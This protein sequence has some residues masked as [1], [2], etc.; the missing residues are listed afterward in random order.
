M[1]AFSADGK[2]V[3]VGR[4]QGGDVQ[5]GDVVAIL[6]G[7]A[8]GT[9]AARRRM[10]WT[11]R[12]TCSTSRCRRSPTPSPICQGFVSEV[13]EGN[14][15]DIRG[16]RRSDGFV[17]AGNHFG[18]R[19]VGNHLLGGGLAWRMMAC[20]TE[21]PVIW[22]WSHVPFLGGVVEGNMLED[23]EQGG[24]V[25]VEHSI[26]I[27]TNKGRTYMSMQ[28]RD[29]VVRWSEP[30]LARRRP[31]RGAEGAAGGPDGGLPAV[32][33]PVRV[34]GLGVGNTPGCPAGLSRCAGAGRPRGPVQRARRS[35]IASTSSRPPRAPSTAVGARPVAAARGRSDERAEAACPDA[36]C[37]LRLDRP[38]RADEAAFP[39]TTKTGEACSSSID[40]DDP[41]RAGLSLGRGRACSGSAGSSTMP[42]GRPSS[43]VFPL[44]KGEFGIGDPQLGTLSSAFMLLYA[45]T[46]PFTGYTVDR[47]SRRFLIAAGLAF[48]S[49]ICAATGLARSFVQL[50]LFRAAEGLGESFYFPASM[51]VL[52]DYHGPRT[53]S[54]AMSLHQTS[55][56]L[57]T[58]GGWYPRRPARRGRR[59]AG[60]LLGPR[61][62]G[63]A[64][65][66]AA[67]RLPDRTAA[68]PGRR[69]EDRRRLPRAA[70]IG[71]T[72]SPRSGFHPGQD[73]G[74]SSGTPPRRCCCASSSARIS[75]RPP[76]WPGCRRWWRGS[77]GLSLTSS[78][79]DLGRSGRWRA[80][81][82][83]PWGAGW[84]T[85][86]P[87][88]RGGGRIRTQCLG[89]ILAAPFVLLIGWSSSGRRC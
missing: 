44:L 46:S 39:G 85:G 58:A 38:R 69:R 24:E 73:C 47:L 40:L 70:T 88:E 14:R 67:R 72:R 71:G 23:T 87:V 68:R 8:A 79:F 63:P 30:F 80:S 37:R 20:P 32:G 10:C 22:G 27:K 42:T 81:R 11:R 89:L 86:R 17:L 5:P 12:P 57:G 43:A 62:R 6:D 78:A 13:F 53:R 49:L 33:R 31:P 35:W 4:P 66:T 74:S 25:G 21:S 59:L 7:P 34:A 15:I 45:L 48:W 41:R 56:Y 51:S 2:V 77:S 55:V 82:G 83:R 61:H 9:M 75:S 19:V 29:N 50:V 76:S 3:R 28:L 18:T 26:A 84:P 1:L 64:L 52:A 16:G 54:R 65:C 60:A 36:P